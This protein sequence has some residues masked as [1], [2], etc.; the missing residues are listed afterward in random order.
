M[1][2]R[3]GRWRVVPVALV[4]LGTA[5]LCTAPAAPAGNEQAAPV[6]AMV[7]VRPFE[8]PA[9]AAGNVDRADG[10]ASGDPGAYR[11]LRTQPESTEPVTWDPCR[12]VRFRV[13]PRGAP[14]RWRQL[15]EDALARVATATGLRLRSVGTTRDRSFLADRPTVDGHRA[16]VLL[17]WADADEVDGLAGPVAGLARPITRTLPTGRL[18]YVSGS[19]LLDTADAG[20][21]AGAAYARAVLDHELGHLL[22]LD[23]VADPGQ[24]MHERS[25]GR[26]TYGVGDLTGLARLGGDCRASRP[27]SG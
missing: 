4:L 18:R 23:H 3:P 6:E 9:A 11:F 20:E 15:V 1:V 21:G 8:S 24:L 19:V 26:R 17:G 7:P 12:T 14:A 2:G 25:T 22:G 10:T 13:D 27:A 5:F 16:P